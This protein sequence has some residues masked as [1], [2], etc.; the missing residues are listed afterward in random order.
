MNPL[1]KQTGVTYFGERYWKFQISEKYFGVR[2]KN[3]FILHYEN[4][5]Y[6]AATTG[7][8]LG[9]WKFTDSFREACEYLIENTV[10]K[11]YKS[12][13]DPQPASSE[14]TI[15]YQKLK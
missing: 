11:Y 3:A 13:P 15:E 2:F 12:M 9:K 1:T 8:L 7:R 6:F 14:E 5:N 10:A 4:S